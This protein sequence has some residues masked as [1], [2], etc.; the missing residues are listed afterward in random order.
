MNDFRS[1]LRLQFF[2]HLAQ[3]AENPPALEITHGNGCFLYD[4]AGKEYLDCIS[5]ISVASLGHNNQKI[6][7][8]VIDQVSKHAHVMVFGEY[9]FES[10]VW[11]ASKL[12][13]LLP[14]HL[15]SV[16]FTNSG[17]EA[18]EGAMKLAKRYSGRSKIVACKNAYHGSTQGAL[19][20]MGNEFFK[21]AFR[22]LLP[23]VHFIEF[24]NCRSLQLIDNHTAAV[25]VEPIQSETGY[26]PATNE[27]LNELREKC[28]QTGAL[29]V[30]DEVQSGMC[31]TG[32][33]F[34]FEHFN[35]FPDVLVLAKALG[36]GYPLG[37]FIAPKQ[38]MDTLGFDPPLGHITTFGG[39]PVSC[40]A[41]LAL[42]EELLQQGFMDDVVKKEK[43]FRKLLSLHMDPE[44][45]SGKGLMLAVHFEDE[46]QCQQTI[47]KCLEAGLIADW[48]LFAPNAMRIT[49][50]LIIDE[51]Q[52]EKICEIIA[53]A[54]R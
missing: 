17:A 32:K 1:P 8:A 21:Q 15:S 22:P 13:S 52:I 16:Y 40:A 18:I 38:I 53:G 43:L 4:S 42:I 3:T 34:G 29:L 14:S 51:Q 12:A 50:P 46:K 26:L 19:S 37:A 6:K 20:L 33:M 41:S 27:F 25:F 9:I 39:H 24:N 54:V 7:Q 5:G 44:R 28:N 49:P 48:F 23:D 11:L 30:M 36:G 10:Q 45:I 31:R 47:F 35:I 2:N